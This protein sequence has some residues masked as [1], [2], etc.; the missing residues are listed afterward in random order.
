MLFFRAIAFPLTVILTIWACWRLDRVFGWRGVR[1]PEFGVPLFFVGLAIILWTN[2]LFLTLGEGTAHPF[3]AK[4]QRLVI[5]GPYRYVRN[6]MM[7][8]VGALLAG[9]ALW[10]GSAG[11]WVALAGFV[12]FISLFVPFY[13]ERDMERRF[14]EE[15]RDYCRRVPR[16]LP[17]LFRARETH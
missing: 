3:A 11:L 1:L 10:L 16:W 13:E 5:A 6:P 4:T 7:W 8:G 9:S 17:R 15:Y 12:T 2:G 14:G